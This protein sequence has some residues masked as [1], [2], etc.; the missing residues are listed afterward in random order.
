MIGVIPPTRCLD[1]S[2]V[3]TRDGEGDSEGEDEGEGDGDGWRRGGRT[4]E[5]ADCDCDCECES[6]LWT[7]ER[8]GPTGS[9]MMGLTM[10][11]TTG[12]DES[13]HTDVTG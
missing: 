10:T 7:R 11:V 8:V 9:D 12:M 13:K 5:D 2:G 1:D 6:I 4:L 3:S